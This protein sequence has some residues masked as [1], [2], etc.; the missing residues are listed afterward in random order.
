MSRHHKLSKSKCFSETTC[1][2]RLQN[3]VF[4]RGT[5]LH[6]ATVFIFALLTLASWSDGAESTRPYFGARLDL[7]DGRAIVGTGQR[8]EGFKDYIFDNYPSTKENI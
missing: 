8:P 4:S 3:P 2:P 6:T 5:S 1:R 7:T